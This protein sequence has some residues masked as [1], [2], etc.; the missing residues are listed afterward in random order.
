MTKRIFD[1]CFSLTGLII[2]SP[3][4]LLISILII[5]T[6]PGRIFFIQ[7]RIGRNGRA[8]KL[9]KFRTMKRSSSRI[10]NAFNPG[11]KC[12][13][14]LVGGFL[15]KYKLD[16]L[17]QFI[18]VL[19]G[20]MSVVGPRPETAEWIKAYPEKWEVILK[21][22]PGITDNA[23]IEFRNEEKLLSA[24]SNPY[25]VYRDEILPKKLNYYLEYVNHNTFTG[26]LQIILQTVKIIFS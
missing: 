10:E 1:I 14:T 9:F 8:F 26:D 24:S 3:F 22:R 21:V 12:R 15:R 23:S 19:I 5:L 17:P 7:P 20:D 18:N 16:E 13:I 11:D 6:M 2:L 4:I 25:K